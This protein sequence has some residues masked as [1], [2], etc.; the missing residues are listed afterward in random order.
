MYTK[1]CF[2]T[3][4]FFANLVGSSSIPRTE[5]RI[6]KTKAIVA[7]TSMTEA[8]F[9]AHALHSL[10]EIYKDAHRKFEESKEIY[11]KKIIDKEHYNY[12]NSIC[13]FHFDFNAVAE[14][15]ENEIKTSLSE[16]RKKK[17]DK[18]TIKV[19]EE[20]FLEKQAKKYGIKGPSSLQSLM[21][22]SF[23]HNEIISFF[24]RYDAWAQNW[25]GVNKEQRQYSKV[26]Y[27][28]MQSAKTMEMILFCLL[29]PVMMHM[30]TNCEELH[31]SMIVMLNFMTHE[32][33]AKKELNILKALMKN[34]N[35][36]YSNK[37]TKHEF[38]ISDYNHK[39]TNILKSSLNKRE[40][41]NLLDVIEKYRK[42]K[43]VRRCKGRVF[44]Q[45]LPKYIELCQRTQIYFTMIYDESQNATNVDSTM[46]K[47]IRL[48][49]SFQ[50]ILNKE[51]E[52][53]NVVRKEYWTATPAQ[54]NG[55]DTSKC[56]GIIGQNHTGIHCLEGVYLKNINGIY[57][58]NSKQNIR[59]NVISLDSIYSKT[60]I[61]TSFFWEKAYKCEQY[62]YQKRNS[63]ITRSIITNSVIT[64][65][66]YKEFV[67]EHFAILLEHCA[68]N[69]PKD[70][71]DENML[72]N[73]NPMIAVRVSNNH[74]SE[75]LIEGISH[76]LSNP[77]SYHLTTFNSQ[78]KIQGTT[79]KIRKQFNLRKWLQREFV[80]SEHE[81]KTLILF[82]TGMGRCG[83]RFPRDFRTFIEFSRGNDITVLMQGFYGRS[84]G[85]HK[86]RPW[87]LLHNDQKDIIEK[88]I[89][90]GGF[91]P[92]NAT[93]KGTEKY[94]NMSETYFVDEIPELKPIIG[95][96]MNI[97]DSTSKK[98]KL[99]GRNN[100][101][102]LPTS[103]L[104]E[105]IDVLAKKGMNV[106]RTSEKDY[107]YDI[108]RHKAP[109]HMQ[110][111]ITKDQVRIKNR[112][113]RGDYDTGVGGATSGNAQSQN[114]QAGTFIPTIIWKPNNSGSTNLIICGI[115]LLCR[116][117]YLRNPKTKMPQQ[118]SVAKSNPNVSAFPHIDMAKKATINK[119][120]K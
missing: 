19:L 69:N 102:S 96:F 78:T 72:K 49:V 47:Q 50:Q 52:A 80:A 108:R 1:I 83:D 62:F 79:N 65:E 75:Q 81:D 74:V 88:Y 110:Y 26:N 100:T 58:N 87:V 111:D 28:D 89:A 24:I 18:Q 8:Q 11:A 113:M 41:N 119:K 42:E 114:T 84:C 39:I 14:K 63:M 71:H 90:S 51:V 7:T 48:L 40:K 27:N 104:D 76:Y 45:E 25:I 94:K 53:K 73:S 107:M 116:G 120:P 55:T 59:P 46:H 21:S 57:M 16:I 5:E 92:K 44:V 6:V 4:Y 56:Y 17:Q 2:T 86:G 68:N 106:C 118:I 91:A 10:I 77:D 99:Q 103:L 32:S 112:M 105:L 98:K 36:I 30:A 54:H 101:P 9:N 12:S 117:A 115:K 95:K 64:H 33:T 43:I 31:D 3:S 20:A 37:K 67:H 109:V 93:Q 22:I 29:S 35:I 23:H 97:L 70:A 13:H 15:I 85:Y 34:V 82:F 60:N 61:P 66:D 38:S